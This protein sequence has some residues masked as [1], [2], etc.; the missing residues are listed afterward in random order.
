[1]AHLNGSPATL[2]QMQTLALTNIGHFTSMRS[3][4]GAVRGLSL[5]MDRLVRDC[6]TVFGSE[7]DP[8]RVRGYVR[9]ATAGKGGS[10]VIRVTIFDPGLEMGHPG[11]EAEP[12][13]LVTTRDAGEMPPPPLTAKAYTFSRDMAQVKHMGL[14]PQLMRR[15]WAQLDGFDD[16]LFADESGRISEGGTWNVGFVDQDNTV[17]WPEADVLPGVT[18]KLLQRA[19]PHVTRPVTLAELPD[20]QACFATNTSIGVRTISAVGEVGFSGFADSPVLD[21]M[22]KA[23]VEIPGERL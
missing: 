10:F 2:E 3:D 20:M 14:F 15:R 1:M 16:A 22:R 7:L 9:D 17:I 12:H 6:R 19:H 13:V 5:H 8:E 4:D 11:S 23:Y 18:M 21:A